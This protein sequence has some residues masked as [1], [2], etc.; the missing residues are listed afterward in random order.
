V[1][2]SK[3][4]VTLAPSRPIV[5]RRGGQRGI[6]HGETDIS[7][8][9]RA[10]N[11]VKKPLRR[12]LIRKPGQG[13]SMQ[14]YLFVS[15]WAA[16]LFGCQVGRFSA[17]VLREGVIPKLRVQSLPPQWEPSH[18]ITPDDDEVSASASAASSSG[19]WGRSGM[20]VRM[21]LPRFDE[22]SPFGSAPAADQSVV[23]TS[24]AGES[25]DPD[26]F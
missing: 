26:I 22:P 8:F 12:R 16:S 1:A 18:R 14:R 6:G 23:R 11:R 10:P 21:P 13:F 19:L 4:R 9:P 20:P 15:L 5:R 24:P 2:V 7:D 3:L 17:S 25:A